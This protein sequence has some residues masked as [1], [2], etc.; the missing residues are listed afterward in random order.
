M[1]KPSPPPATAEL[2]VV[3]ALRK[4]LAELVAKPERSRRQVARELGLGDLSKLGPFLD[5]KIPSLPGINPSLLQALDDLLPQGLAAVSMK[6]RPSLLVRLQRARR[7]SIVFASRPLDNVDTCAEWDLKAVSKLVN[8]LSAPYSRAESPEIHLVHVP[9]DAPVADSRKRL[10]SDE[11]GSVLSVGSQRANAATEELLTPLFFRRLR[12]CP[13]CFKI[14]NDSPRAVRLGPGPWMHRDDKVDYAVICTRQVGTK[15]FV[16]VAG[17]GGPATYAG[18]RFLEKV[19]D[20]PR[21][22]GTWVGLLRVPVTKRERARGDRRAVGSLEKLR[23]IA[24]GYF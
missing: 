14:E 15:L 22:D 1:P 21:Q 5:G 3:L 20:P 2:P 11:A 13:F 8:A 24:S 17:L 16:V 19:H 10:V 18:C 23:L 9:G 4:A 7:V 6:E 12:D